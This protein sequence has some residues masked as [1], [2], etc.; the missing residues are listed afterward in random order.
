LST[1]LPATSQALEAAEFTNPMN[2]AASMGYGL[3]QAG[4]R[5]SGCGSRRKRGSRH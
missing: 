4:G 5:G 2:P 1:K 3:S